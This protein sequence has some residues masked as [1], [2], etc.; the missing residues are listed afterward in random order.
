MNIETLVEDA[1]DDELI[2]RAEHRV[3]DK[4]RKRMLREAR[5]RHGEIRPCSSCPGW[6]ESTTSVNIRGEWTAILWY[7]DSRGSTHTIMEVWE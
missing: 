3:S 1:V 2:R 6:I 5:Y 4:Q 7:N